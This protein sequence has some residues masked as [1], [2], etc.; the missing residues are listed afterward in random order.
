[1]AK[2]KTLSQK[3][4][5]V[6]SVLGILLL[7]LGTAAV[8]FMLLRHSA[9]DRG[10]ILAYQKWNAIVLDLNGSTLTIPD[11]SASGFC[12]DAD[13]GRVFYNIPSSYKDGSFDLLYAYADSN[14]AVQTK[15]VD[16]GV[17]SGFDLKDGKVYYLKYDPA[18]GANAGCV[19]D[20]DGHRIET[21]ST[22]VQSIY[23]LNGAKG[24]YFIK[25]HGDTKVLYYYADG[26]AQEAARNV[27]AVYPCENE[28]Q[29]QLV[30]ETKGEQGKRALSVLSD[31]AAP[32]LL[33]DD[34]YDALYAEYTGG[35]LYFFTSA[36]QN[37]SWSYVIADPYAAR[38]ETLTKPKRSG[39][40]SWLG[41]D[42]SY[43]DA[44]IEYNQKLERDEIRE[45]LD[46]LVENGEFQA[47]VFNAYV[48]HNGAT[49]R[50]AENIDPSRVSAV[51]P[52]GTPML[53]YESV[54]V[55]A[56]ETDMS[57]LMAM[58]ERSSVDEV[59]EYAKSI[60]SESV[61]SHGLAFA[62]FGENGAANAPL[63][64]YDKSK[65]VFTFADDGS[66]LFAFVR[67][68]TPGKLTLYATGI[69]ADL[70][71]TARKDIATGVSSYHCSGETVYYLKTDVG[72]TT[73]DV[74][75]YSAQ[76]SEKLS[77][78]AK[79][80]LLGPDG[81]VFAIKND[82]SAK[83]PVA[84]YFLCK[85]GK[86]TLVA[87]KVIVSSF[88]QEGDRAAFICED[89]SLQLFVNGNCMAVDSDVSRLLLLS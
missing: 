31:S 21:F 50:I 77:N 56:A 70:K 13:A 23:A 1:M 66:Q 14:G 22:N 58:A 64:G 29:P 8:L 55:S 36:V 85:D 46:A 37:I 71:P 53:V 73:G 89:G 80:F 38:D 87:E 75:A 15:L 11:A 2:S 62:A 63:D 65:T 34:L 24:L 61:K 43:N 25:M 27:Q 74:F 32:E 78:A 67:E 84:D 83:E 69:G 49:D 7:V 45:A 26:Q 47:P 30:I 16:Y 10:S 44:L 18:S 76:G 6:P 72:K 5:I 19:C 33:C 59:A 48:Y 41:L 42:S 81:A 86:E 52:V 3:Q 39:F 57:A 20:P 40:L 88:R 82:S 9:P 60:V 28:E 17:E 54:E 4:N 79:A 68:N 51:S 35:N 12:A